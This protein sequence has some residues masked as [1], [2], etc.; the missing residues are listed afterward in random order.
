MSTVQLLPMVK[1][2]EEQAGPD[3]LS[4]TEEDGDVFPAV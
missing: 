3:W 2:E 4:S 1:V